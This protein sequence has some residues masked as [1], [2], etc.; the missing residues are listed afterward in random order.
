MSVLPT[1]A[2]AFAV[3]L[4]A[5]AADIAYGFGAVRNVFEGAAGRPEYGGKYLV[6]RERRDGEWLSRRT[7]S[8]AT[9]RNP[10]GRR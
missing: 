1:V 2:A 9:S 4:L 5:A 8:A 3:T 7:A 6:V 10:G